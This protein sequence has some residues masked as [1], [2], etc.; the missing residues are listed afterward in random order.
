MPLLR[1]TDS[2]LHYLLYLKRN[3]GSTYFKG[4]VLTDL[5]FLLVVLKPL[6][7][8]VLLCLLK[9][10]SVLLLCELVLTRDC[11]G[12]EHYWWARLLLRNLCPL[13]HKICLLVLGVSDLV[14]ID[15]HLFN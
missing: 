2:L 12:V 9:Q 7:Q 1:P 3:E 13:L 5:L 11:L 8:N 14:V 10:G 15:E 4:E 6:L